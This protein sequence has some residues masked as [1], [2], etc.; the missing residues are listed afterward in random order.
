MATIYRTEH[1]GS[2]VRPARLLDARDAFEA[3][4]ISKEDLTKVEDE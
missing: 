4:K 2:M 1:V 3:G